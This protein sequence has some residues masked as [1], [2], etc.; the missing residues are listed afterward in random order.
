MRHTTARLAIAATLALTLAGTAHAQASRTTRPAPISFGQTVNGRLTAPEEQACAPETGAARR[1]QFRGEEGARFEVTMTSPDFDTLVEVGRMDGCRFVSLGSNDDGSGEEDGLNSRLIGR[2]P[3]TGDYVIRA[4]SFG[5]SGSGPFDL[6]LKLLPPLRTAGDPTPVTL[7]QKVEGRFA[8]DDPIM[9]DSAEMFDFSA[10]IAAAAT[11]E[12][13]VDA[14]PV[15]TIIE[16]G[17]PYHLYSL[18]GEAGQEMLIKFDS[19]EFD[20]MLEVGVDSPLGFSVAAS[21]D[22]GPGDEDGLNSRLTVKFERAGTLI[23]RLSPLSPATG[24]YTLSVETPPTAGETPSGT[25]TAT[26]A[27]E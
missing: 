8:T 22:D 5:A 4:T 7:G 10:M 6:S 18:T 3:S 16:S 15:E 9:P 19:D 27:G 11:G 23:L 24:A 14:A 12:E 25:A 26:P 17:R 21:N 20:P 13:A 2:L 1:Y